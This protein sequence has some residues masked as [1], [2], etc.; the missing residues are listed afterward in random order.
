MSAFFV[1]AYFPDLN[2]C[3]QKT[4]IMLSIYTQY[5]VVFS[6]VMFLSKCH[7]LP[8]KDNYFQFWLL[9]RILDTQTDRKNQQ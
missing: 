7:L 8:Q 5:D 3:V 1:L 4:A 2:T 9:Q 6:F